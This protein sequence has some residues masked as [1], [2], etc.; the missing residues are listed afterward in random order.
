[1]HR[2]TT[3]S[4][5]VGGRM[6]F[7]I[8]HSNHS[9]QTFVTLL[10]T[11]RI[12][13]LVD[14]RSHPRSTY[15]PHFDAVP[16]ERAVRAAGRKYLFLGEELGGRPEG[17]EYYDNE[18]FVLY[19]KVARTERFRAAIERLVR[20]S[21][22]CRIAVMCSEEDPVG[23]HRRLLVGRVLQER[24]VSTQHIRGNGQLV[25]E[26]S[27]A[28]RHPGQPA[29]FKTSEESEWKSL[30]SVLRRKAPQSSF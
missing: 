16:L 2:A 28:S 10:T 12:E 29:L 14:V 18:G 17:D 23:C 30:Q 26:A 24:G 4:A 13:V 25:S 20:G 19:Y 27:I 8:G 7:T 9:Q 21:D 22:I 11:H 6:I 15:S 5:P 1:V 3:E